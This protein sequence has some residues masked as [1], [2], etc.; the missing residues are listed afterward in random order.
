MKT[1]METPRL[2]LRELV[3]S[4]IGAM[5]EELNNFAITRNTARVPYPYHRDDAA[6]FLQFVEGLDGKSCVAAITLKSSPE[7]LLGIISYEWNE[8]K[9]DAEL[10]YWL[11]ESIWGIGYGTEAAKAMV[12][13]VFFEQ[14][15]PKIVAC[16]HDENLASGR[17]LSKLGFSK[18]GACLAYSK[19]RKQDVPVTNMQLLKVDWDKQKAD[20]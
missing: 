10:G 13:H 12:D 15:H 4:D 14:R 9:Q 17:I 8:V 20:L 5:V 11:S 7:K 18:V 19:A 16:Y 1:I 2:L 6:E 3:E